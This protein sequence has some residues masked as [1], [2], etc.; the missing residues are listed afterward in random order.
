[1]KVEE[2]GGSTQ[3]L[4]I[5]LETAR[6]SASLWNFPKGDMILRVFEMPGTPEKTKVAAATITWQELSKTN[7]TQT[8]PLSHSFPPTRAT[9]TKLAQ[10]VETHPKATKTIFN[11]MGCRDGKIEGNYSLPE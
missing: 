10:K 7:E 1:M 9:T 6:L 3:G 2:I 11:Q 5:V 8:F 4:E